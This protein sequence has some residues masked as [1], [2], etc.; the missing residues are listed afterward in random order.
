MRE[1]SSTSEAKRN[2]MSGTE[3]KQTSV[4]HTSPGGPELSLPLQQLTQYGTI[5]L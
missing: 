4:V 1:L 2:E 5:A 3:L